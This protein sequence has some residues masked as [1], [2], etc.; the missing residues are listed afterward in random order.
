MKILFILIIL[1]FSN[2]AKAEDLNFEK[3]V[4]LKDP[5]GSTFIDENNILVT[6]KGGAIKLINIKIKI[7]T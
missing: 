7:L 4:N 3:L 6:E 1:I 2:I 5:W